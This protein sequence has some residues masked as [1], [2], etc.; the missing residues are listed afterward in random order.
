MIN[1]KYDSSFEYILSQAVIQLK[2]RKFKQATEYIYQLLSMD[3]S[4]PEP[5]NLCGILFEMRGD[6][7]NARKHYRA[8]Y[9]LDPDYKP[10]C[11]NLERMVMYEWDLENRGYDYGDEFIAGSK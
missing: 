10:S 8:A 11:R 7:I 1:K 4:A 5:H 3:L 6:F 9:A 2:E